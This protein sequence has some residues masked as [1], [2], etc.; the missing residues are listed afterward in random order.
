MDHPSRAYEHDGYI[1]KRFP[2][3][4]LI[5]TGVFPTKLKMKT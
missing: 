1:Q 4:C 5:P 3:K 2:K